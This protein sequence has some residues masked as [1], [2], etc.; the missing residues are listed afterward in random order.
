MLEYNVE[1][2]T[3]LQIISE[4]KRVQNISSLMHTKYKFFWNSNQLTF[5]LQMKGIDI[6]G[7]HKFKFVHLVVVN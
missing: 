2:V 7:T 5:V 3:W 6:L 4:E 1:N